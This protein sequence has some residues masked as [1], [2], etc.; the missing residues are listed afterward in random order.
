MFSISSDSKSIV[1]RANDDTKALFTEG[2]VIKVDVVN[3]ALEDYAA[4][5]VVGEDNT[6]KDYT[7]E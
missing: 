7:I 4:N 1:L 3:E 6:E 2:T 5:K